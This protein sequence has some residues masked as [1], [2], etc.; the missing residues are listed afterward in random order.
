MT[1]LFSKHDILSVLKSPPYHKTAILSLRTPQP[2]FSISPI[3]TTHCLS[4]KNTH[5]TYMNSKTLQTTLHFLL[6][7]Q[8]QNACIFKNKPYLCTR[9]HKTR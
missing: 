1:S 8:S 2:L 7:K 4:Q 3:S 5:L 9:Y 6:K